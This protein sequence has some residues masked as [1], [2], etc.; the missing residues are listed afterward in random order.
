V[1]KSDMPRNKIQSE[2]MRAESREKILSTARRLFAERGYDGCKVSEI[3]R[4]ANMSQ[5]NLYWYFSSKE[6]IFG[7][8]LMDGF[9]TLGAMMT[10]AVERSGSGSEKLEFFLKSFIALSK[11]DDG[12][13]FINIVF[14][15][16]GQRGAERFAEFGISTH[17]IGVGYHQAL[18]AILEQGQGEGTIIQEIDPNLLSTFFFSLINGL[19]FMYPGEWQDI[20]FEAIREAVLRLLG[21]NQG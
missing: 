16:V 17:Q 8:V 18:N 1:K 19:M 15:F 5:G 7:A 20:P 21:A 10:E 2:Q 12:D 11:E 9:N 14:N 4:Q 6:E 13:E 3:A